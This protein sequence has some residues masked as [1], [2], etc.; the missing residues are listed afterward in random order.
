MR[1]MFLNDLYDPRIGSSV[2]Q[3]YQEAACLR[4]LGHETLV[5][6]TT[7]QRSEA[8][9]TEIEGCQ[10]L[11]LHSDYP[12]RWRAWVA[13][14]N[15]RVRAGL[16]EAL[17]RWR[18]DVVHSHLIHTHLGYGSLTQAARSGAAVVFTAHDVMTFCY[19]KLTC[20]HGGEAAGG[21]LQ[22]YRAYWQK[23]I[24][25]QRLRFRPGR[26][27]AIRQVLARDVDRLT[28]VSDALGEVLE[29]NDIRVHRTVHNALRLQDELPDPAD[30]AAFPP[31]PGPGG[32]GA[33]W[34]S[35][36]GCT[37]RRGCCSSCACWRFWRRAF[38]TWC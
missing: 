10:V 36:A 5:V 17:D 25:C 15:P 18:P 31:Q 38:P 26:N 6:T 9:L 7:P 19:Q 37:S 12:V 28:V 23:C 8:G 34:R 22:D 14:D 16:R 30:V 33:C 27:A 35:A 29:A 32:A 1:V 13:L 2:R 3:M 4:D 21:R 24:P 20:F 11:R